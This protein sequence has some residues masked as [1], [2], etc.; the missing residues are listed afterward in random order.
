MFVRL[1]PL[2]EDCEMAAAAL[3]HLVEP[4]EDEYHRPHRREKQRPHGHPLLH[5]WFHHPSP[6]I[7]RLLQAETWP[8][9]VARC[10]TTMATY[11]FQLSLKVCFRLCSVMAS[12]LPLSFPHN[13]PSP[14][15]AL[16][17][18][19]F[20]RRES[21]VTVKTPSMLKRIVR[22]SHMVCKSAPSVSMHKLS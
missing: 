9:V 22:V 7:P 17:G 14:G 12:I 19:G 5:T 10:T 4:L 3:P 15:Q 20:N 16:A 21:H 13:H 6:E 2:P 18:R 11:T 1:L 8:T